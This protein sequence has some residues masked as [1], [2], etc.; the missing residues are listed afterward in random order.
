LYCYAQANYKSHL[1]SVETP[2]V[3]MEMEQG[4]HLSSIFVAFGQN[5]NDHD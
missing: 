1:F 3:E 4:T 2:P 5:N